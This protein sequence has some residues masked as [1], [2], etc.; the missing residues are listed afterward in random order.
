MLQAGSAGMVRGG[1][2]CGLRR[3]LAA[4]A[5]FTSRLWHTWLRG[6]AARR[7]CADLTLTSDNRINSARKVK[8]IVTR[9][10][11]RVRPRFT[12]YCKLRGYP[13]RGLSRLPSSGTE[14]AGSRP[15]GRL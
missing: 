3:E 7:H 5:D 6:V 8:Q 10:P 4:A 14:E 13:P 12:G 11:L 2:F 9:E 1:D 15:S